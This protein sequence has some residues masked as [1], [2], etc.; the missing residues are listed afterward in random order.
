MCVKLKNHDSNRRVWTTL[1]RGDGR[2][3]ELGP[4]ETVELDVPKS[5]EDPHLRPVVTAKGAAKKTKDEPETPADPVSTDH[6][7]KL[8]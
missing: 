8:P 5:F 2:T 4:G 3:L 6:E 7:E 1:Q